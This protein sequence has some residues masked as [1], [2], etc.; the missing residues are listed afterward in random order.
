MKKSPPNRS[1]TYFWHLKCIFEQ[2]L[3]FKI[4]CF[5]TE[6]GASEVKQ[7]VWSRRGASP[8]PSPSGVTP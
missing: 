6:N 5:T 4:L 3:S 7:S 2:F 8:D 1:K